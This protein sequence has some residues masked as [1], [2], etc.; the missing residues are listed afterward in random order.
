MNPDACPMGTYYSISANHFLAIPRSRK[1]ARTTTNFYNWKNLTEIR[2]Y[3][4]AAYVCNISK[5]LLGY[6]IPYHRSGN[7]HCK[8]NFVVDGSYEN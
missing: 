4:C 7:F 8:N 6:C 1:R 3:H 2:N 5:Q